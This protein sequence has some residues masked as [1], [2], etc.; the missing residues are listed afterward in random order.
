MARKWFPPIANHDDALKMCK[1]GAIGVLAF[2]T[3]NVAG[4]LFAIFAQKSAVSGRTISNDDVQSFLIGSALVI[5]LLLWLAYR[6]KQGRGWLASGFV[7]LWF[8]VEIGSKIANGTTNPGWL[9]AYAAIAAALANGIRGSW[10]VRRSGGNI[11]EVPP[12]STSAT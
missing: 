3:M 9:I 8:L 12:N 4:V 1:E 2:A 11:S 10:W 7:L 6:I 5:P